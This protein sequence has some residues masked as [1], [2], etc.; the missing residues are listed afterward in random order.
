MAWGGGDIYSV[1]SIWIGVS[2]GVQ[3]GNIN[4]IRYDSSMVDPLE[5]LKMVL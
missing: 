3:G 4:A 2:T 1:L 5:D